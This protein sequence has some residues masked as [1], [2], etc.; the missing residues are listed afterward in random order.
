MVAWRIKIS[1]RDSSSYGNYPHTLPIGEILCKYQ[2]R[3]KIWGYQNVLPDVN[4]L[5]N[6]LDYPVNVSLYVS[7]GGISIAIYTFE[8]N[9]AVLAAPRSVVVG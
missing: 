6:S 8:W 5:E 7:R 4:P 1:G 9:H 2:N 3:L